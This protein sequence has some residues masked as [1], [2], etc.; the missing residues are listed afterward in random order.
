VLTRL[1]PEALSAN[2]EPAGKI[3]GLLHVH[4]CSSETVTP[5][6]GQILFSSSEG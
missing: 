1:R 3:G 5:D 2:N 4:R 6:I